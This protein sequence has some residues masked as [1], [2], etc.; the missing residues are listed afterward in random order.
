[1]PDLVTNRKRLVNVNSLESGSSVEA[2][3]FERARRKRSFAKG[4]S[5][6]NDDPRRQPTR[7]T[8]LQPSGRA[9]APIPCELISWGEVYRLCRRLAARILDADFRPEIIVAIAR[10]GVVPA[11]ILCDFF[12]VYE[13]LT[14]RVEHYAKG[15]QPQPLARIV[16]PLSAD[17]AARRILLVDDV[18]DTGDTLRLAFDH[19]LEVKPAQ[20][21]SAVLH[22]KQTA[23]YAPDFFGIELRGWR[24][25]IYPWAVLED[26]SGFIAQMEER[27]RDPEELASRLRADYGIELKAETLEDLGTFF[28]VD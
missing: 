23:T 7:E 6:M 26:L 14:L 11:R 25:L 2:I 8:S 9:A 10:G 17:V 12:S 13:L 20:L 16:T 1:M 18:S 4:R 5:G 24:W 22:H 21:K 27:P 19:L 3:D 28:G 15:A